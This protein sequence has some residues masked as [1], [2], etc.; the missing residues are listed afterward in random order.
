[1]LLAQATYLARQI[2]E[3]PVT[4]RRQRWTVIAITKVNDD[5]SD[6]RYVILAV[7]PD[8]NEHTFSE[9]SEWPLVSPKVTCF[10]CKRQIPASLAVDL[11]SEYAN[12]KV[13]GRCY[14]IGLYH[15]IDIDA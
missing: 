5:P 1:M 10:D 12:R 9:P 2:A 15:H 14:E 8:G 6:L 4:D 13:C 11:G 3:R 7:D